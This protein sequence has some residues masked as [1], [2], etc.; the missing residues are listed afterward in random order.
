M[1]KEV[2]PLTNKNGIFAA[3]K[4]LICLLLLNNKDNVIIAF[5]EI[6]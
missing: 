5:S 6:G 4:H 2:M 3:N 1:T